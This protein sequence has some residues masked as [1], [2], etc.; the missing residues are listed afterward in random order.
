MLLKPTKSEL[1]L[2]SNFLLIFTD[3]IE[4]VSISL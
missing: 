2:E 1:A 3:S 4:R